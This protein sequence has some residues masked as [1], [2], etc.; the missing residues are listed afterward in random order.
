MKP[1]KKAKVYETILVMAIGFF[2]IFLIT[3]WNWLLLLDI[4]IV[5][6]SL[7]YFPVAQFIAKY[8]M[9]FAEKLG[10]VNSKIILSII[11]FLF[12]TP[13]AFFYRLFNKKEQFKNSTWQKRENQFNVSDF[14]KV[15]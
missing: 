5:L 4:F 7:V 3:K 8:W 9:F 6:S 14:E 10:V 15:W 2:V 13:I 11:F 1:L 12:L